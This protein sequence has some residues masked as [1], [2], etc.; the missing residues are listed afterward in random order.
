MAMYNQVMSIH[1]GREAYPAWYGYT[2]PNIWALFPG[3][4][5]GQPY[6]SYDALATFN[7]QV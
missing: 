7:R 1:D 3:D 4:I 2:G 5:T 6:K